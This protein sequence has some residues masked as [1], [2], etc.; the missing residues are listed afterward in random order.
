MFILF[1]RCI[2]IYLFGGICYFSNMC[3]VRIIIFGFG[4][5]NV[6]WLRNDDCVMGFMINRGRRLL[7]VYGLLFNILELYF[8]Y[9]KV[10]YIF[11][12]LDEY[13]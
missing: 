4:D 5:G 10:Y 13:F 12:N 9:Y 7:N 11:F 8:V 1:V 3:N 6:N 2:R